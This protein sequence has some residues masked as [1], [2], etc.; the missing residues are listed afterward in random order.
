MA[1]GAGHLL[2]V[3]DVAGTEQR[4]ASQCADSL[5]SLFASHPVDVDQRNVVPAPGEAQGRGQ[6]QP[7]RRTADHQDF[8]FSHCNLPRSCRP[9]RYWS[10]K[11]TAATPAAA[12]RCPRPAVDSGQVGGSLNEADEMKAASRGVSRDMSAEAIARRFDTLVELERTA[13]ALSAAR[14]R[15]AR[16]PT[17]EAAR[18]TGPTGEDG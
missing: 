2:L 5:C 8:P 1:R 17:P 3:G 7:R 6:A 16:N 12:E 4:L 11:A 13:R 18:G 9:L 15:P 14:K 10:L